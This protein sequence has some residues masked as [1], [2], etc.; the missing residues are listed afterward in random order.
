MNT[1]NVGLGAA[2]ITPSLGISMVG[3][4]FDRKAEGIHDDLYAK[5]LWMDDGTQAAALVAC[6]LCMVNR[7]TV[8]AARQRAAERLGL[9]PEQLLICATHTHT[10]PA[11]TEEYAAF[12][13]TRIADAVEMAR[14]EAAPTTCRIGFGHETSIS[15]NRR[16][17]MKDGSVVTNPGGHNPNVVKP[18]GPIDPRVAVLSFAREDRD[19]A[20]VLVNFA[21]HLDTIG[22]NLISADYPF[23]TARLLRQ[24]YGAELPVL[25]V[26]GAA[27]DLNHFDV[28]GRGP[29][30]GFAEPLR[31]GTILG[32]EVLKTLQN[33]EPLTATPVGFA[34]R[35]IELPLAP[36]TPEEVARAEAIVSQP[37]DREHD[38]VMDTV[39]AHR[40]VQIARSQG[41][42]APTEVQVLR[43]GDLAFV[44]IPGELFVEL[45]LR[46]RE[47]SPLPHTCI[48]ELA[49]DAVGYLPPRQAFDEG[50]YEVTS[51]RYTPEVG[52]RV[53]DTA[54][55]LLREVTGGPRIA[56]A[57]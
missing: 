56:G 49:N 57:D 31:I 14:R 46:I 4:Y 6:D 38:F 35:E 52:E 44:G 47:E 29:R 39:W 12:A 25:F 34:R 8:A 33:M 9:A 41:P 19:L 13:A 42:S 30:K 24:V 28:F 18:V 55:E 20:G 2:N 45:G 50:G 11:L 1:L 7:P 36:V 51:C 43:L 21:L 23:F 3:Y 37:E 5:C 32:A 16:F 40:T 48:I 53:A 27:G 22:G 10:G 26:N 15:F 17:W 54:V